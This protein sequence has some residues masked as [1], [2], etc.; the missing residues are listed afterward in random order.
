MKII[1]ISG[2][3]GGECNLIFIN[4]L[5]QFWRNTK[6]FQCIGNPKKQNLL[7]YLNGCRITYTTKDGEVLVAES[8]DLVY[9]PEGSEYSA[10]LS[11]FASGESHT[12]GIN[13]ILTDGY[14]ERVILSKKP[15]IIDARENAELTSLVYRL[16]A[17]DSGR[18]ALEKRIILL[19]ILSRL[20]KNAEKKEGSII[21]ESIRYLTEH[22][23]ENPSIAD[24]A[25]HLGVSE[26]YLRRRFKE[27]M[28]TSP[29]K[30]RNELRLE[31]SASYL[32]F[33]DISV[34]EISDTLGY[35][36]ASHFIKEF[37]ERYGISPLQ[38]RK[39]S[40]NNER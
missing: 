38:Y 26:V 9:T 4:A 36:T 20:G 31:R 40:A 12:V 17:G 34:Q 11:D 6:S 7:L 21:S 19:D 8:G 2:A 13:F 30:Y 29:A 16:E 24:L 37:K 1:D 39:R 35:A 3:D 5:R 14:G 23:D 33:G 32:Q 22:I 15:L 25:E 28:G 27:S 18:T 10:T